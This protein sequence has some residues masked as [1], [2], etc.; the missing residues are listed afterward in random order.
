M[1]STSGSSPR[2]TSS[3]PPR[4]ASVRPSSVSPT[5]THPV[6]RFF[7]FQSPARAGAGRVGTSRGRSCREA[8]QKPGRVLSGRPRS[9]PRV[10]LLRSGRRRH[11]GR[12]AAVLVALDRHAGQ[13][14]RRVRAALPGDLPD[15]LPRLQHRSRRAR[16]RRGRPRRRRREPGRRGA[17]RSPRPPAGAAVVAAA[18][19]PDPLRDGVLDDAGRRARPVGAARPDQQRGPAGLRRDGGRRRTAGRLGAR[20]G[21][22]YW[23]INLGFATAAAGR[24]PCSRRPATAPSSSATRSPRCCSRC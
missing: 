23:A 15:R 14:V 2:S 18:L 7:S 16:A 1:C 8:C 13:P 20:L 12:A 4:R 5:S 6:K 17:R 9:V 19:C 22:N 10:S 21:L 24:Q 3:S 11:G